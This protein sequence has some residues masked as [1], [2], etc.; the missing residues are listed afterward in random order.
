MRVRP[1][2][3]TLVVGTMLVPVLIGIGTPQAVADPSFPSEDQVEQAQGAVEDKTA[4]VARIQQ[5][6]TAANAR[7]EDA[8]AALGAAAE[9]YDAARIKLDRRREAADLANAQARQAS[10]SLDRARTEVGQLAAQAYIR[11]G[12]LGMASAILDSGGP[13]EMLDRTALIRDLAE[14]QQRVVQKL[15][16]ARVASELTAEQTARAL[17][18][19]T[20]AAR[21]LAETRDQAEA[22]AGSASAIVR[23]V[24]ASRT[25]LTTQLAG[26]RNTSV[27]LETQRQAGLEAERQEK[28]RQ[29]QAS[30]VRS[31]SGSAGATSG[32]SADGAASG[33]SSGGS[34]SVGSPSAGSGGGSSSG[35][36]AVVWAKRQLGLPYLWGGSGPGSYDCSGL[37]MQA[38]RQAGVSLPHY[39]ASQYEQ[40][41]KISYPQMRPGDLIFYSNDTS[42]P[43]LIHHVT[44]YVG[45]GKMIEAPMTGYNVRIVPIRWDRTMPYAGRP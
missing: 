5:E 29:Q 10:E 24:T 1:G 28:L 7:L 4:E 38:W 23:Q 8:Q 27:E 13:Q 20:E 35:G 18:E 42:K 25:A 16:S 22:A 11:G 21:R 34:A 19:Q 32:T 12:D 41:A 26:L 14:R 17:I 44:M 39:A 37:T 33:S 43:W 15:D 3:I 2:V 6:L 40:S 30:A 9:A 45:N 31:S 36:T